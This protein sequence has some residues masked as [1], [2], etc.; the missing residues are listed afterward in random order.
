MLTEDQ[1]E[2]LLAAATKPLQQAL[3]ALILDTG[4]R[5]GE[6]EDLTKENIRRSAGRME[7]VVEG[8]VGERGVPV[9]PHVVEMLEA[10]GD[11]V[12]IWKS[13]TGRRLRA[14]DLAKL[15][16][17]LMKR[18][19]LTGKRLGPHTLRHTFATNFII[20]GGDV[21]VLKDL[22]GHRTIATTQ[23]YVTLAAVHLHDAHRRFGL[24][25][26]MG[27]GTG[28]SRPQPQPPHVKV[29]GG[30][31]THCEDEWICPVPDATVMDS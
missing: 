1:I 9:S 30:V 27:L 28:K 25:A 6:V 26:V 12:L 5:I 16:M 24:T 18:S 19:G 10:L 23:K 15:V 4:L 14:G 13:R 7:V 31:V 20:N 17:R 21:A 22:L 29:T 2:A 11:D 3:V 8:K